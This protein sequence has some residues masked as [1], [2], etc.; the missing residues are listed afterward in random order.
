MIVTALVAVYVLAA[1]PAPPLIQDK[2]PVFVRAAG[3]ASG[4]TDPSRDRQDSVKDVEKN[5]RDSKVVRLVPTFDEAVIVL[6]VLNR[7]TRREANGWTAFS[8]AKQNKS[9]LTVKL[10]VGDFE[11]ELAGESGSK[12]VLKGYGAA[13][14]N[15]VDQ[16]DAWV[17]EN[18]DR[19]LAL[20]R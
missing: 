18:R 3:A 8:G 1:A 13:A 17:K 11:T 2:I 6:D 16:L 7:E 14:S 19:L 12:G 20:K 15:V 5:I 9:Y 4:F 10:T